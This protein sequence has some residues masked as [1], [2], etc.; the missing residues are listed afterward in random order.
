[1]AQIEQDEAFVRQLE[2][3]LN[4]NINWNDVMEQV[5]RSERED[6]EALWKLVKERFEI[7]EPKNFSDNFLLNILKIMFEKPNI[8]A[9][10]WKDQKGMYGLAKKYPLTHFTLEQMLNNVRLEVKEESEMSL[11]LLRLVR[12]QL[13]ER[14]SVRVMQPESLGQAIKLAMMID[15]NKVQSSSQVVVPL[16]GQ[17]T[18]KRENFRKMTES[19]LEERRAKGLCFRRQ[20]SRKI[21]LLEDKQIPSVGVFDEVSF[22]T[23]FQG[24]AFSAPLGSVPEPTLSITKVLQMLV[25]EFNTHFLIL[26]DWE[27]D[28]QMVKIINHELQALLD[29]KEQLEQA[30]KEIE[31]RNPE[32][33]KVDSKV[34]NEA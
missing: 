19:E 2:A 13:N 30:V 34:F 10:V 22:Y 26:I 8:K 27:I 1:Q 11:E 18:I 31:L 24:Q 14:S 6:L 3:E 33:I 29:K 32:I 9:N 20:E 4:A 28:G 15:E 5:K 23:L 7:I 12:R 25:E 17:T 16:G 21:H